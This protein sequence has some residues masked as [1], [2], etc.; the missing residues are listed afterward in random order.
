MKKEFKFSLNEIVLLCLYFYSFGFWYFY[1]VRVLNFSLWNVFPI[2]V[3]FGVIAVQWI[4]SKEIK[5]NINVGNV[6]KKT[7]EKKTDIVYV[8]DVEIGMPQ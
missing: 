8:V 1:L 4:S 7:K 3:I 6:E 5:W 2:I